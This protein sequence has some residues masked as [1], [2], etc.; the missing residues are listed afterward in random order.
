MVPTGTGAA[1]SRA[2]SAKSPSAPCP[3]P[4]HQT[5]RRPA[6]PDELLQHT[7]DQPTP[8]TPCCA[9]SACSAQTP[10]TVIRICAVTITSYTGR[11]M[12]AITA[13]HSPRHLAGRDPGV[14]RFAAG[15]ADSATTRLADSHREIHGSAESARCSTFSPR[16]CRR[17][18]H[19]IVTQSG[20]YLFS[21][22]HHSMGLWAC[23]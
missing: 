2:S 1:S 10:P 20:G 19:H 21:R 15:P 4:L 8:T 5:L 17:R 22:K 12:R 7:S 3:S 23:F 18:W 14:Q 16:R 6:T 13:S 11:A 9:A